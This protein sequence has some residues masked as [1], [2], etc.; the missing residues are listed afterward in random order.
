MAA[1]P[2]MLDH[3]QAH[4]AAQPDRV[5]LTQPVG[6]GQVLSLSWAQA[7]GQARRKAALLKEH[8]LCS[9]DNVA[10]LAKNSAHFILAE[11]AIWMAG[12]STVV[13]FPIKTADNLRYGLAH[14]EAR[15]LFTGK[16]DDGPA[17]QAGLPQGLRCIALPLSSAVGFET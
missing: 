10:L 5:L 13:I 2:L 8:G 16:L 17:Q 15:W 1:P 11:R 7:L 3:A 12:G 14:C 9:G 4:E 6:A